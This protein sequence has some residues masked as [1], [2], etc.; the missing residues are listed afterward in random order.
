[1]NPRISSGVTGDYRLRSAQTAH[2]RFGDD[3]VVV[4][5]GASA[6]FGDVIIS[7]PA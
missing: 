3:H 1:M 2:A 5:D 6:A 4:V 7:E